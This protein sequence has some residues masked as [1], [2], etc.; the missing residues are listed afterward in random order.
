[1]RKSLMSL[2]VGA[3]VVASGLTTEMPA[4][5]STPVPSGYAY[6]S[7]SNGNLLQGGSVQLSTQGDGIRDCHNFGGQVPAYGRK[8][9]VNGNYDVN[10]WSGQ[11][12]T[13]SGSPQSSENTHGTYVNTNVLPQSYDVVFE[14]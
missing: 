1:M 5:A 14:G 4:Y 8:M 6:F 7:D 3:V 13:S 2:G 11:N 12:C 10:W 9:A